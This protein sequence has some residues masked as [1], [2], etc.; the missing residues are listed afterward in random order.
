M[1]RFSLHRAAPSIVLLTDFGFKDSYVG[2]MKGVVRRICRGAEV[3]DLSH[4]IM[5]QDVAEAA[6]VLAASYRYFPEE[7][8]FVSVV[9][10]GVG[11][12]RA[13]LCMRANRQ[14]FLA[15]DNGLLSVIAEESGREEVRIVSAEQYFLKDASS[16]FHGR[17]I[18]APVAA[19]LAAGLEPAKLGPVV[20]HIQKL[21]LPR[22]VRC[23]DGSFRGEIIYIDQFGNLITNIRRDTVLRSFSVP[24][25]RVAVGIK[26]R[27]VCGISKAY[28]DSE[29]GELLALIGSS[30]YLE[31]AVNRGSAAQVLGCEKGDTVTL[32]VLERV[33]GGAES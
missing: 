8:I 18:F 26:R 2:V 21:R 15:P 33:S 32:T 28:A 10:P 27:S 1:A 29:D 17:D 19:H 22:P 23:V 11:T 14:V 9:D 5:P 3:I 30:G 31:V 6:F 25:D 16:T 13:V 20:Q 7:T 24:E 4:N 12:D